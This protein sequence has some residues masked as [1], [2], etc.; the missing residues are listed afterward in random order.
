M[1]LMK[2]YGQDKYFI[3]LMKYLNKG[4]KNNNNNFQTFR[5]V[6]ESLTVKNI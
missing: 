3:D 2:Y 4:R 6:R 1:K 5:T